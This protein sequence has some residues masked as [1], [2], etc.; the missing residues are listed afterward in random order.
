MLGIRKYP[1]SYVDGSRSKVNADVAAFK[2]IASK[3]GSFESAFF[4]NMVIVLDH[5]FVH[6]LRTVEGKD[7]NPANEVRV[8]CDSI[9]ENNGVMLDDKSIKLSS[10]TSVLKYKPGDK[11]KLNEGQFKQL[12]SAYFDEIERKFV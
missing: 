4:N 11:I 1:Q 3:N 9:M 7:G 5:L 10:A 8:L 6:R 2:K 12:S